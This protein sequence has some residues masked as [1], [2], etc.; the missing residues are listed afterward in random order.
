MDHTAEP[1]REAITARRGATLIVKLVI[2]TA[3]ALLIWLCVI[4][5]NDRLLG[6]EMSL[7][8]HIA[9]AAGVF[10]L[11]VPLI[12][13]ARRYLDRQP[14]SALGFTAGQSAW[15]DALYGGAAWLVPAGVGAMA[16][17]AFGWLEIRVESSALELVG[18]VLLLTLLAF[19]Y[20]AL[21][22]ELIFRGYIYR[23]LES[24]VAPWAAV[25]G[26]AAL[27]TVW[28]TALW[29]ILNGWDVLLERSILFLAMGL[30]LGCLRLISDSL[31][32]TIGFHVA[33][34]V[35][36]QLFLGRYAEI[37]VSDDGVF[38]L[39]IA[40]FAFCTATTIAG[41]LWPGKHRWTKREPESAQRAGF[42]A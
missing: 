1:R 25:A 4:T 8:K 12:F 38:A 13:G 11:T 9:N 21:P 41:F 2:V 5:L 19:A 31:W 42:S 39:A 34:Q 18:A 22:E 30:V 36:M 7:V 17:L 23:N 27:F 32:A 24:V 37:D 20:E 33:F 6:E 14:P 40:V 15:R 3:G 10:V 28:G 35:T 16:C 29:V 26:Q